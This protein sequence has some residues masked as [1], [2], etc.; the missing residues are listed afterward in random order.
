MKTPANVL[1]AAGW[2]KT[3]ENASHYQSHWIDPH[4][5]ID[6]YEFADAIQVQRFRDGLDA[7]PVKPIK[8]K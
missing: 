2:K 8:D 1:L 6:A 4:S 5:K 7:F 3:N